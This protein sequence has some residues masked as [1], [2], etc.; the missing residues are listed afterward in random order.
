MIAALGDLAL[1]IR[2]HIAPAAPGPRGEPTDTRDHA[3]LQ[4]VAEWRAASQTARR[5]GLP[6]HPDP[7]KTWDTLLAI[8]TVLRHTP[9]HGRILDA[10]GERYSALLPSLQRYGYSDLHAINLA[11]RRLTR[12]GPIHYRPG[13]A[14]R[15]GWPARS[16]HAITCLSV[17]EHGVDLDALFAEAAR[18]LVPGGILAISTDYWP[19]PVDTSGQ[20][21]YGVPIKIFGGD[22]LRGW[23]ARAA[24]HGFAPTTAVPRDLFTAVPAERAVTWRRFG[25]RYTFAFLTLTLPRR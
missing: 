24:R 3:V 25:L 15:T 6:V 13:D 5:L 23:F 20:V 9:R 22:E 14:T 11:F 16:A 18:L 4:S 17:V 10:G 2:Q 1:R 7:P 12:R 19:T 8:S 21:A